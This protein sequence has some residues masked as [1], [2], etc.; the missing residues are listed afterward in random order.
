MRNV[1]VLQCQRVA[2]A[3]R[4]LIIIAIF[5]RQF[6]CAASHAIDANINMCSYIHTSC[7]IVKRI[8]TSKASGLLYVSFRTIKI[9]VLTQIG[10]KYTHLWH[11]NTS[12]IQAANTFT[13][14]DPQV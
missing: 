5:F 2:L 7:Y 11:K 8:N 4:R 1:T 10:Q 3:R 6:F 13:T 12:I 14:L 9:F